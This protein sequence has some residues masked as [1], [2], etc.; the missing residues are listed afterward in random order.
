MR[1]LSVR[2][3]VFIAVAMAAVMLLLGGTIFTLLENEVTQQAQ[4]TAQTTAEQTLAQIESHK[5]EITVNNTSYLFGTRPDE[6]IAQVVIGGQV[7]VWSQKPFLPVPKNITQTVS[8]MITYRGAPASYVSLPFPYNGLPGAVEVAVTLRASE[9]ALQLL[10]GLLIWTG[11]A[12]LLL[13]SLVGYLFAR[14]AL[15]PVGRLTNLAMQI[16]ESD[17]AQRLEEPRGQ[18]ELSALAQAFNRM[19]DRLHV[20]FQRQSRFVSDAS[21]EMRTPLAVISG[22]AELLDRWGSTQEDVRREAVSAIGRE[23]GRLQR[24]VQDLLFLARGAQGLQ[25]TKSYFDLSEL[26]AETVQEAEALRSGRQVVDATREV[27]PVYA[28]FDL[29]KQLLW[30]LLDN[31]IKFTPEGKEIRVQSLTQGQRAM[32]SVQDEGPGMS[33]EAQEH[34]FERFYRADPARV[35]G[36]GVGLG[37]A[38][39]KEIADAHRARLGISSA[40]GRGT[41]FRLE[42]ALATATD[43]GE[44]PAEDP[45]PELSPAPEQQDAARPG[46]QSPPERAGDGNQTEGL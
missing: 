45:T 29:L 19:L 36:A 41:T 15:R 18:D 25:L 5:D 46:R 17:L 7:V 33:A 3:T 2:L 22:Y 35:S 43:A 38:I 6:T 10:R 28:D 4:K 40:V 21:H 1:S 24:L 44:P 32:L 11:L 12:G 30:I 23:A 37:L 31:A 42:L 13:V 20:A 8:E 9:D 34:A 27:V 39:A 16:S 26:V 14:R